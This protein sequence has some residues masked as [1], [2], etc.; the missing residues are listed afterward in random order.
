MVY[1]AI[2]GCLLGASVIFAVVVLFRYPHLWLRGLAL[3]MTSAALIIEPTLEILDTPIWIFGRQGEG[4]GP[5]VVLLAL[6][7]FVSPLQIGFLLILIGS[8]IEER[9]HDPK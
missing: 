1:V 3:L 8:V 9:K 4:C 5:S 2:Y 7:V 6:I